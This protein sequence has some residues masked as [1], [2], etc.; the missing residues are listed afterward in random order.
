MSFWCL[1]WMGPTLSAGHSVIESQPPFASAAAAKM[2]SEAF[3][4]ME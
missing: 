1:D 4:E 3:F 2:S